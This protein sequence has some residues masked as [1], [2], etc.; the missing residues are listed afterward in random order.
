MMLKTRVLIVAAGA[1]IVLLAAAFIPVYRETGGLTEITWGRTGGFIGLDEKLVIRPNGM[2]EYT[3][4]RFGN[5]DFLL[6]NA[7]VASLFNKTGFFL[8]DRSYTSN[9]S[10]ADYYTYRM[11]V[12]IGSD[13]KSIDWVDGWASEEPLPSELGEFQ[14]QLE[15][16][17][18]RARMQ[19]EVP[20][21]PA[22]RAVE[23][24]KDFV[25]QAPTFKFDGMLE[26]LRVV[27]AVIL[28]SFPEQHIITITFDSRQAGYGD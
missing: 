10:A 12:Q 24:A 11:T 7:E 27:E 16:I 26:T 17:V 22:E 20:S 18:E 5:V 9:S 3:S 13:V 21:D 2:V 19:T 15:S 14:L 4:N 1:A 8:G 25:V 6:D 23:I 28:E